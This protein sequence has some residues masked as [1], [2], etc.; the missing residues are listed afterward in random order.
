MATV[1]V[2]WPPFARV[3]LRGGETASGHD[4]SMR[5]HTTFLDALRTTHPRPT[6]YEHRQCGRAGL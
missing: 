6:F 3:Y 1:T 2:R 5:E 4:N